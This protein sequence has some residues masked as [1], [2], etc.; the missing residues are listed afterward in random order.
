MCGSHEIQRRR[1]ETKTRTLMGGCCDLARN[2]SQ[3][4]KDNRH[5]HWRLIVDYRCIHVQSFAV[6]CLKTYKYVPFLIATIST[7]R[8]LTS[9]RHPRICEYC[10][11]HLQAPGY[12]YHSVSSVKGHR[13]FGHQMPRHWHDR[14]WL[15]WHYL[16]VVDH[17][18][19]NRGKQEQDGGPRFRIVHVWG[20]YT[21]VFFGWGGG[22]G[23]KCKSDWMWLN[24]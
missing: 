2:T 11:I 20:L 14:P 13:R 21:V 17:S 8:N 5:H 3:I 24:M 18:G 15:P 12:H 9:C 23:K 7:S 1:W 16:G 10:N 6:A 4:M 19:G 22:K